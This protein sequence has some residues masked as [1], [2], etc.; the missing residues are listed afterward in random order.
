MKLFPS[1]AL[2]F[3]LSSL[4]ISAQP[5][6]ILIVTDDH[7]Y[8]DMS[9]H[10]HPWLDTPNLDRLHDEGISLDDYHVDPYC[11]PTRAALM[12]GRYSV[13]VGAWAVTEG[14][15]L[16]NPDETTMADVF[17]ASG[18][19]TGMFG[20]WH[21]GDTYPYAPRYRGFQ[22]TVHHL[23]GGVGEIGNPAGNDYFDDTYYRDGV[24]EDFEGYCT[25]VF[26]DEALRFIEEGKASGF[27]KPFFLYLPLNAMHGPLTVDSRYSDPFLA[28]GLHESLSKF[29]GMVQNFDENLGQL[30]DSLDKWGLD[31]NTMIVFMGDNGTG[32]G[33]D[34]KTGRGFNAGMRDKKG[35]TYE[36][37][38]RVACFIRW[39]GTLE[40]GKSVEVLTAHLDWLPTFVE[41]CDLKCPE[42][43]RLDGKSMAPL[44]QGEARIW[45]ERTL[46]VDRQADQLEM[47][48][49]GVDPKAKYPSRTVL[50]ERWRLVN[51]ELYDI[52]KDPGQQRDVAKQYPEVV[53]N[54]NQAYRDHFKDVTS[55]GGKY[56]PFFIGSPIENPTWFTTRDWHHTDGGVIWKI[57]LVEDDSLFVNG[58]WS[59]DVQQDGRYNI[60]LSR[61]PKDAERSI[62]A[63]RVRIRLGEYAEEKNIQPTDAFVNFEI[64]LPKG[65]ALLQTWFTDAETQRERGAYYVWAEYLGR[66]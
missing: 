45:S 33:Y 17:A 55:H 35:S 6:V 53:E 34:P 64:N 39:P 15:Q 12:T 27:D 32:G 58:F 28:K 2:V 40:E 62:G 48:Y 3:V 43:L 9:V 31:A 46:F 23:A 22:D 57:E 29:L 50:T 19:R 21:L 60:R 26:F 13:R 44:L 16:L 54:L 20:K 42:N 37:G 7:G 1:L 52:V 51:A 59:L 65:E 30:M 14:R 25:N 11:T 36:G 18:Y 61:F 24:K 47:W 63:N 4:A 38:H 5:N 10:G 8:G 49:S 56:T 66:Y 41:F